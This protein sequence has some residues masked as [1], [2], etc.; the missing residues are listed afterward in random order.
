MDA[1]SKRIDGTILQANQGKIVRIIGKLEQ[2]DGTNGT[3][4]SNGDVQLNLSSVT[5]D[6]DFEVNNNYEVIGKVGDDLSISVYSVLAISDNF[7]LDNYFQ[8]VKFIN[9]VPELFY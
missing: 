6:L 9:K 5:T 8:L 1:S 2:Y 7:K 4:K 3:L